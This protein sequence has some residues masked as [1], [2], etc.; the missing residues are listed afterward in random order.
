MGNYYDNSDALNIT[1][2]DYYLLQI[3]IT[4]CQY[5]GIA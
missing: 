1:N 3:Q 2:F 5:E 4:L